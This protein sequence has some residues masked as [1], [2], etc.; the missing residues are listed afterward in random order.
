MSPFSRAGS[1][2]REAGPSSAAGGSPGRPD[3]RP[4][5]SLLRLHGSQGTCWAA[6]C[7]SRLLRTAGHESLPR[8]SVKP[9]FLLD[10]TSSSRFSAWPGGGRGAAQSPSARMSDRRTQEKDTDFFYQKGEGG[11][12]EVAAWKGGCTITDRTKDS[13]KNP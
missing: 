8:G 13:K 7:L 2:L 12:W 4:V 10:T 9:S 11:G 6:C 5:C 3:G 1:K